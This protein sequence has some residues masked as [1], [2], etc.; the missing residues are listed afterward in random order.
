MFN[1]ILTVLFVILFIVVIGEV[2]Y[3]FYSSKNQPKTL[4]SPKNQPIPSPSPSLPKNALLTEANI[5]Y[6]SNITRNKNQKLIIKTE[7]NGFLKE[8]SE[9][10]DKRYVL[11]KIIDE[12]G[13]QLMSYLWPKEKTDDLNFYL[14]EGDI[15]TSIS[16]QDV[17]VNDK[18]RVIDVDDVRDHIVTID[19][20]VYR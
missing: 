8:I 14:V 2:G 15:Q 18:L 19:V 12:Q 20:F 17:K 4:V 6:L 9:Y 13:T 11:F 7:T 16:M 3:F 1:K 5:R 10:T